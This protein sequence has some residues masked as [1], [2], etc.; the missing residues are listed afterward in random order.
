MRRVGELI[1]QLETMSHVIGY[2]LNS[3]DL[4]ILR[5]YGLDVTKVKAIDVSAE[6]EKKCDRA[7]SLREVLSPT[8]GVDDPSDDF[9]FAEAEQ[10]HDVVKLIENCCNRVFSIRKLHEYGRTNSPL[11]SRSSPADPTLV[12]IEVEW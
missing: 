7:V 5:T 3:F 11:Y 12:E 2:H 4:K 1:E 9:D 8:L 6:L 10:L